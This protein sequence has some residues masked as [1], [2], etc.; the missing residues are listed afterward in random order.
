VAFFD[1]S[2]LG[3]SLL[4]VHHCTVRNP[5]RGYSESLG[6]VENPPLLRRPAWEAADYPDVPDH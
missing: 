3:K 2:L 6:I 5:A 4:V 1:S